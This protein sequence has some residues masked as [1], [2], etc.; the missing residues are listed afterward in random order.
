[1][2]K[3]HV[4]RTVA[5]LVEVELRPLMDLADERAVRD[6]GRYAATSLE[7]GGPHIQVALKLAVLGLDTL[8][9]LRLGSPFSK[10]RR[11]PATAWWNTLRGYPGFA[12]L[13]Q[14]VRTPAMLLFSERI[15]IDRRA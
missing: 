10:A 4:N 14:L 9:V 8:T 13:R 15:H 7:L 5:R 3:T 6:A 12:Q 2:R 1:V 11:E